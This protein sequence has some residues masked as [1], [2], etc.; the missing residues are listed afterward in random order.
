MSP[1]RLLVLFCLCPFVPCASAQE[2]DILEHATRTAIYVETEY[3]GNDALT[4]CDWYAP[5][6]ELVASRVDDGHGFG[7]D[8]RIAIRLHGIINREGAAH[9]A[10][11]VERLAELR[12]RPAR[13]ALDSQG[14][15]AD[16][17]F[18]IA[19]IIR[20]RDVFRRQRV[21]TVVADHDTAVCFSAC[22]IIFAAGY[23]RTA[24]FDING[25]PRLASR[26]GLHR[27]GQ[28]D[29]RRNAYDSDDANRDIMA[30]EHSLRRYFPTVGVSDAIVD[31]MFAVAFDDIHLITRDE[32]VSW[33]LVRRME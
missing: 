26:L 2:Y 13:I 10:E 31:A 27:P 25:D 30:V 8:C 1:R 11:V 24:E 33:G 6:D 32:A 21:E 18:E 29:R 14:G 19:R 16:A 15:D 9:F 4:D 28:F 17:A 23:T 5:G 22:I 12:H 3:A 7:A 20:D